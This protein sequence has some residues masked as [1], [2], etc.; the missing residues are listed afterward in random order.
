[1]Q[2]HTIDMFSRI[3][4]CA[5]VR[6]TK[7]LTIYTSS[8]VAAAA[9]HLSRSWREK[10]YQILTFNVEGVRCVDLL[11]FFIILCCVEINVLLAVFTVFLRPLSSLFVF[12]TGEN[13]RDHAVKHKLFNTF[14]SS[15]GRI[16][17]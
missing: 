8:V 6:V 9:A 3:L 13:V 17:L 14:E 12:L 7:I 10:R 16:L 1:M 5:C 11:F 4:M 15:L 2:L